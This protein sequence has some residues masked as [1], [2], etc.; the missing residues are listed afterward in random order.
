[1][2]FVGLVS[3]PRWEPP[4]GSGDNDRKRHRTWRVPWSLII[5]LAIFVGGLL[6]CGIDSI[7]TRLVV[8]GISAWVATEVATVPR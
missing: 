5:W 2:P 1:M 4:D 6:R 7:Q 3:D 8:P